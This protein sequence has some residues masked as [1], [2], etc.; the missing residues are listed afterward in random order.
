MSEQDDVLYDLLV[1]KAIYGLDDAEQAELD[2]MDPGTVEAEFRSLELTAA[3]IG[4]AELEIEPLPQHLRAGIEANALAHFSETRELSAESQPWPPARPAVREAKQGMSW[5]GW[6]GWAAAAAACVALA[7]NIW[8][9]R[10]QPGPE[11]AQN[12][13]PAA[14]P[15]VKQPAPAEARDVLASTASDLIKA[16]WAAGNVKGI[17]DIVGDIIWSDDKQSGYMTFR[18]LP[19]NDPSQSTYQLWIMDEN[20]G[21]KT[22]ID[23]GTFNVNSDGE[24]VVPVNAHLKARSPHLFAVTIEKPGGVVVSKREKIAAVAKVETAPKA[25][26]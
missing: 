4:L 8:S 7:I 15:Y 2:R 11:I 10:R 3:A 9:T 6:L 24:V 18:G 12:P 16:T 19:P 25:T 14:T 5:F 20:Q 21:D 1:K 26:S 13:A 17:S 23:G 22:P